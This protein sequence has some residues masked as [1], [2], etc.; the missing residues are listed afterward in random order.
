MDVSFQTT[1]VDVE[2]K[3]DTD[4]KKHFVLKYSGNQAPFAAKFT[5]G[6]TLMWNKLFL[7]MS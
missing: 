2:A 1:N 5:K 3:V 7:V 6:K 4:T